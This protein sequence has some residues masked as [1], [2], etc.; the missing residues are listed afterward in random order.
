M[1]WR[2]AFSLNDSRM[3]IL[4]QDDD[5]V[6][7]NK[8]SG[9]LSIR[10]G[11]NQDFPNAK[12]TLEKTFEKVWTVHRLDKDTSGVLVFALNPTAHCQLNAQFETR[13]TIKKYLALIHGHPP[14]LN[15]TIQLPLKINGDR[16]HRTIPDTSSGKDALTEI[17]VLKTIGSC[18]VVAATP[19]TG[20]THQIRSHLWS[21][22]FP[23]VGDTLYK[24]PQSAQDFLDFPRL[25]LHAQSF[26]FFHYLEERLVV[27]TAPV[28]RELEFLL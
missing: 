7:I 8:P 11:Y 16:K 1:Y 21:C 17:E 24:A 6:A 28:P 2:Q 4:F 12:S 10:D 23:I 20:Y 19:H 25:A 18:S 9:L 15:F 13:K 5:Y 3:E 14:E 26:C 27:I 22:D